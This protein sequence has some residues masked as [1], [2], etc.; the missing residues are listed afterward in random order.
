MDR[1]R[2]VVREE[3]VAAGRPAHPG[4][5]VRLDGRPAARAAELGHPA[6]EREGPGGPRAEAQRR[7]SRAAA[8]A[9]AAAVL[10]PPAALAQAPPPAPSVG[11]D[12]KRAEPRWRLDLLAEEAYESNVFYGP[13]EGTDDFVTSGNLRLSRVFSP[14]RTRILLSAEGGG[15]AYRTVDQLNRF[16][17]GGLVDLRH[18]FTRRSRVELQGRTVR[19]YMRDFQ[20]DDPG[21]LPPYALMRTDA[22]TAE[23]RHGLSRT[24]GLQV[25]GHAERFDFESPTLRDGSSWG[26]ALE[27]DR[28]WA[29]DRYA[30]GIAGEYESSKTRGVTYRIVRTVA[31]WRGEPRPGLAFRLRG[32]IASFGIHGQPL[33]PDGTPA[34]ADPEDP[35]TP[36]ESELTPTADASVS[37]RFGRHT[38]G[39]RAAR[40]VA[41]GYGLG[42]VGVYGTVYLDYTLTLGPVL[43]G[44][45]GGLTRSYLSTQPGP[46]DP[47]DTRLAYGNLRWNATRTTALVL[48][49]S[50]WQRLGDPLV[51]LPPNVEWSNHTVT[52]SIQQG[53]AWR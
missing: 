34:P 45:G 15:A 32:G 29:G 24:I 33:S 23:L 42:V 41:Q 7:L 28:N 31:L 5:D 43:L 4:V 19:G 20:V 25:T 53:F 1:V 36:Q 26:G 40:T 51:E 10:A 50:Y 27:L 37:G 2:P 22:G 21:V 38:F 12:E 46:L 3:H 17:W 49:Y 11:I 47:P 48:A 39:L 18:D 30:A 35:P 13:F 16:T 44:A 6:G 9:L 52:F 8:A 14:R